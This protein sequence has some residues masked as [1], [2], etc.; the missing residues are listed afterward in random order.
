MEA[1]VEAFGSGMKTRVVKTLRTHWV[2]DPYA[3]GG[4]SHA[5]PGKAASRL[6]FQETVGDRIVLAGEHCSI[7]FYST[8]HGA[9]LSGIVAAEKAVRLL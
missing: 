9:H 7:P 1:M 6:K 3:L 8:V 2:S 5:K 4:Y